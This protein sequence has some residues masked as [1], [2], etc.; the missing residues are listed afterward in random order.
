MKTSAGT[1]AVVTFCI[2]LST[3]IAFGLT[4]P[5]VVLAFL[6]GYFFGIS[7][8]ESK[9]NAEYAK[10]MVRSKEITN[11]IFTANKTVQEI[12]LEP[13]QKHYKMYEKNMRGEEDE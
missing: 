3:V 9:L 5:S 11:G 1:Y 4:A 8:P 2:F 7:A 10:L 6:A 13:W 12:Q